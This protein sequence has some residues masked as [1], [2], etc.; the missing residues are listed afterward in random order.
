ML[1]L[2]AV[3]LL[4]HAVYGGLNASVSSADGI[5]GAFHVTVL[6]A[7]VVRD[8]MLLLKAL[9]TIDGGLNAVGIIDANDENNDIDAD[10][11]ARGTEIKME[12]Y[13]PEGSAL[14]EHTGVGLMTEA[15]FSHN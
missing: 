13:Y 5:T 12:T 6:D 1:L 4:T 11:L 9:I 10:S 2:A 3:M 7:D 8:L 15:N 14:P